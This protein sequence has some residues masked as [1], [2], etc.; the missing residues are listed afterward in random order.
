M[1]GFRGRDG[2][3][4]VFG[5]IVVFFIDEFIRKRKVKVNRKILFEFSFYDV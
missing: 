5:N 1:F 2:G 4:M 3:K